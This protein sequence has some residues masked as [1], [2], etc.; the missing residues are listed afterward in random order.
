MASI[1]AYESKGPDPEDLRRISE[2]T[3]VY[4]FFG[5]SCST[6][7]ELPVPE[8]CVIVTLAVCGA[9]AWV[10]GHFAQFD[11]LFTSPESTI[12]LDPINNKEQIEELLN[13]PKNSLNINH[14]NAERP[15]NRMYMNTLYNAELMWNHR[16]FK[17]HT[18]GLYRYPSRIKGKL[19]YGKRLNELTNS[20][21]GQ[22]LEEMYTDEI[23]FPTKTSITNTFREL[24]RKTHLSKDDVLQQIGIEHQMTQKQLFEMYPGIYYLV[25]CRPACDNDVAVKESVVKRRRNSRPWVTNE[26]FLANL[27]KMMKYNRFKIEE[28]EEIWKDTL[29]DIEER[30]KRQAAAAEAAAA[31]AAAMGGAGAGVGAGAAAGHK[32]GRRSKRHTRRT[33]KRRSKADHKK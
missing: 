8:G 26:M 10:D 2:S 18:S 17:F 5:H 3:P 16:E 14:P 20:E 6:G 13:L 32:G 15:E 29:K 21:F 11:T 30:S 1:G 22:V 9:Y 12:L 23:I 24:R 28:A 33:A 7:E 25:S 27:E 19:N 4:T 31:E